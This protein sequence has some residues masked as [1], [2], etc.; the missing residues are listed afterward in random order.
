MQVFILVKVNLGAGLVDRRIG[1]IQPIHSQN[2]IVIPNICDVKL[3]KLLVVGLAVS[4]IDADTLDGVV[5]HP[6]HYVLRAVNVTNRKWEGQ[7]YEGKIVKV[8]E[9]GID[10]DS[11]SPLSIKACVG[12]CAVPYVRCIWYG[13]QVTV[14]VP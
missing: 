12:M 9:A 3:Y 13:I 5:S 11:F 1:L 4:A 14:P 8:G 10:D 6:A 7:R 2:N